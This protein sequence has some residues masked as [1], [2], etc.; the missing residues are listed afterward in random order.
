MFAGCSSMFN[1]RWSSLQGQW[2]GEGM[3]IQIWGT[4]LRFNEWECSTYTWTSL[5]VSSDVTPVMPRGV[6]GLHMPRIDTRPRGWR[7]Y[8]RP[9]IL[10]P[11]SQANN[12]LIPVALRTFLWGYFKVKAGNL[13]LRLK[14]TWPKISNCRRGGWSTKWHRLDRGQ[15]LLND[16]RLNFP[17][18]L[19]D[20]LKELAI[21][22]NA[23]ARLARVSVQ[24]Q[25]SAQ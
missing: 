13:R 5:G 15:G 21:Q 20:G 2:I 10:C 14:W 4:T 25:P 8:H 7:H 9:T 6:C 11:A 12:N 23:P 1:W 19:H 16:S 18:V 24:V 3:K 22:K 17:L